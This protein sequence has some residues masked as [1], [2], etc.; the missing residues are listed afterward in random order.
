[1]CGRYIQVNWRFF[2]QEMRRGEDC[3]GELEVSYF[4]MGSDPLISSMRH[5][6]IE[7]WVGLWDARCWS[8]PRDILQPLIISR[9]ETGLKLVVEPGTKERGKLRFPVAWTTWR[10][11]LN[12]GSEAD[13]K[14]TYRVM[15]Y[16][17]FKYRPV[18]TWVDR[19]WSLL[20]EVWIHYN[21]V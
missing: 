3:G 7:W 1:M 20:F 6:R 21:L 16:F 4:C 18:I 12:A 2:N 17:Q 11:A 5:H 15:N 13:M 10:Y 9:W 19:I 8:D 14:S